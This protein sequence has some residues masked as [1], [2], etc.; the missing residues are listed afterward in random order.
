[1]KL[2]A[3][4]L[5]LSFSSYLV[6]VSA[7]GRVE[8]QKLNQ[9]AALLPPGWVFGVQLDFACHKKRSVTRVM[10]HWF[11]CLSF[12]CSTR[13]A[14]YNVFW[15]KFGQNGPKFWQKIVIKVF[16]FVIKVFFC[17]LLSSKKEKKTFITKKKPLSSQIKS[18][19]FSMQFSCKKSSNTSKSSF[20]ILGLLGF[21]QKWEK[22]D[23]KVGGI[24]VNLWFLKNA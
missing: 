10:P 18:F 17:A 9:E 3:L 16:F 4:F 11:I 23:D 13:F 21:A 14:W 20:K 1:M 22:A 6:P 24:C 19:F 2:V 5:F 15:A 8:H 12:Y 7:E